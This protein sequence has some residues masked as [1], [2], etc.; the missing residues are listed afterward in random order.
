MDTIFFDFLARRSSFSVSWKSIF[1]RMLHSG[2]WKRI[3]WL[4]QPIFYIFSETSVGESFFSVYWKV[5]LNQSFIQAI[6]E[7]FFSLME[8]VTL[9][10]SFFLLAET[11]MSWN[12]FLKTELILACGNWFFGYWKPFSSIASYI[13]Q[14]VLHPN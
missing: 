5:F 7:G 4:L 2:K 3:F 13:F 10:A 1:Q 11:V 12:Q 9:L 6:G 8:T 14:G